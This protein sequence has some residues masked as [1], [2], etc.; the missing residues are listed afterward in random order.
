MLPDPASPADGAAIDPVDP[1]G[2]PKGDSADATDA[3]DVTA[4]AAD[5]ATAQ[6]GRVLIA[7]ADPGAAKGLSLARISKRCAL[8]MSTL[9]RLLTGLEDAGLVGVTLTED[10]RG[11][12]IL[13]Q[14]GHTLAA[15][16]TTES[17][18]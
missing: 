4:D 3:T 10:G 16:L 9:R 14:A 8:P 7:L 13:T 11:A 15:S 17:P 5:Q 18:K 1:D 6:L 2:A 12:A